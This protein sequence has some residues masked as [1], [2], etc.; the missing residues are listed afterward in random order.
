MKRLLLLALTGLILFAGISTAFAWKFTSAMRQPQSDN[1]QV[2]L[3]SFETVTFPA[4]DGV[5]L[6]G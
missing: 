3:G 4:R 6:S 2:F 5:A 1:P